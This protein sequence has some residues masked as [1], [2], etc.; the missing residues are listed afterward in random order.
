MIIGLSVELIKQL[1]Q[2]TP[3]FQLRELI[4]NETNLLVMENTFKGTLSL[5][6]LLGQLLSSDM[7]SGQSML[8]SHRLF[9]SIQSP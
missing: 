9:S 4:S 8:P 7:S 5:L 6:D 1:V 2:F 3:T